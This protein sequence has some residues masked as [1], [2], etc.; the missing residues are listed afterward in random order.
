[1]VFAGDE[2]EQKK[3]SK[4]SV[5]ISSGYFEG[6]YTND[7]LALF[8]LEVLR[9]ASRLENYVE[10]PYAKVLCQA[11]GYWVG[12]EFHLAFH[13]IGHGLRGKAFGYDYMMPGNGKEDANNS[14]PFAKD[15]NFFK[16]FV[17]K[18]VVLHRGDPIRI[19]GRHSSSEKFIE[20]AG[21][22]NNNVYFAERLSDE[23]YSKGNMS[24]IESFAYL[25]GKIYPAVYTSTSKRKNDSTPGDPIQIED[26]YIENGISARKNDIVLAGIISTLASGTTYSII[27]E[28]L[29]FSEH[30][31]AEPVD[32]YGFR[33][34]DV[35]SYVTSKGISYKVVSGYKIREDLRLIFG[36]EQVV[37]G[38]SAAEVNLGLNKTFGV[39]L[40][41]TSCQ[42]VTTFGKGFNVEA[43]CSIPVLDNVSVNFGGGSYA[44]KSLIGERHA[45]NMKDGKN[46][47]N[48]VFVSLSYKY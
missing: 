46:R 40:N 1:M 31:C 41:N 3:I 37:H 17:K 12:V 30:F 47:S 24:S 45:K 48:N 4:D 8:G 5:T 14:R 6:Q 11:L 16:F 7:Q 21:G 15:E 20:A 13:E 9:A 25:Y 19:Q 32:F 39:D 38:K 18:L 44:C 26:Y 27:K 43:S 42:I 35:F 10:N 22:V 28:C 36:L 2:S 23:L 34:P 29:S 33:V